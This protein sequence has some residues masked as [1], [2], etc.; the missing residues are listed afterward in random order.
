MCSHVCTE[1]HLTALCSASRSVLLLLLLFF[2]PGV[3]MA[4]AYGLISRELYLGLRFDSDSDNESQSRVRSQAGLPGGAAPGGQKPGG[5][6]R[7]QSFGRR[8]D[9]EC[10]GEG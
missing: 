1:T 6:G 2:V 4:V 10:A 3:V 8:A 5:G 9:L 7:G